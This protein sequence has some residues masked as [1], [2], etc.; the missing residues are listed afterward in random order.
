MVD[1]NKL[2]GEIN[3]IDKQIIKLLE[4]RFETVKKVWK[5]KTANNQQLRDKIHEKILID[6]LIEKSNLSKKFI[7]Q[8]Y[9]QILNENPKYFKQ[10]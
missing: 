10:K 9:E 8:I 7:K 6:N 2:R 3:S 1:I 4:N 5:I